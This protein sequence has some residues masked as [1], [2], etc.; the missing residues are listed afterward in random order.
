MAKK[1]RTSFQGRI[2]RNIE[3]KKS[4]KKGTRYLS[5]P[6]GVEQFKPEKGSIKFDIMP[7]LV[8]DEHHLDRDDE[9]GDAVVGDIWWKRPFKVHKGVGVDGDTV[10]CPKTIGKPCPICEHGK[11]LNDDGE[12]W[13]DIKEIFAKDR[14]LY[15]I[16]PID[17]SNFDEEYEEKPYVFDMSYHLFEKQLDEELGVDEENEVFPNLEG[18]K[19]LDVRF[20][21]KKF[22]KISFYETAVIKFEDREQDYEDDY[23]DEMPNLDEMLTILSYDQLKTM[24]FEQ[25]DPDEEETQEFEEVKEEETTKPAR[26]PKTIT[27]TNQEPEPEEE[28]EEEKTKP[29]RK[30]ASKESKNKCPHGHVYGQDGNEKDECGDCELWDD[31]MDEL[32][33]NE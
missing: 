20:R 16:I 19:T 6:S 23:V 15:I 21:E 10:V 14:S 24:F 17:A 30:T 27:K 32:E 26:K 22:G 25:G 4:E 11:K 12:E 3:K 8:T 7:Y 1:K 9:N 5:L 31:C 29:I 2:G 33:K 13:D 28:V 18:G